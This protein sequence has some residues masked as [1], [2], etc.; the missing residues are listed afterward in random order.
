MAAG[1][2]T[3][4]AHAAGLPVVY[5]LYGTFPRDSR[6]FEARRGERAHG[7]LEPEPPT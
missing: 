1:S 3:S 4:E 7:G 2:E 6:L 5:G